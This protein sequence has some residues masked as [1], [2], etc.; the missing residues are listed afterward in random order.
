MPPPEVMR[1]PAF[2]ALV[3]QGS[4]LVSVS[5]C[6]GGAPDIVLL[7][8][9]VPAWLVCAV[10]GI[11][12]GVLVRIIFVVTGVAGQL[13]WQLPVCS[14]AGLIMAVAAWLLLFR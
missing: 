11:L 13:P 3:L 5:G 7:G 10:L 12:G 4:A 8:T 1:R 14:S 6:A 9:Y 2:A